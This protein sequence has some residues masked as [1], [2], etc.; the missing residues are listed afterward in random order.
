MLRRLVVEMKAVALVPDQ[1]NAGRN[2]GIAS[3]A[4]RRRKLPAIVINGI[5]R[6]LRKGMQNVGQQQ[7]L[8]LLFVMQPDLEDRKN[9]NRRG[10][11]RNFDQLRHRGIHMRPIRRDV[12]RIAGA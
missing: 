1:M 12:L 8:M 9:R 3:L 4:G 11:V 10:L 2:I 5:G 6:V 7:F